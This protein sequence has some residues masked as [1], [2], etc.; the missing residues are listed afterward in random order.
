MTKERPILFSTPMVRALRSGM[1][2]QTRRRTRG[3]EEIN[4][5]PDRWILVNDCGP[6]SKGMFRFSD[7][8]AILPDVT[9]SCPYGVA[10]EKLWTRESAAVHDVT[11][12]EVGIGYRADHPTGDLAAGDGGYNFRSISDIACFEDPKWLAKQLAW[13]NKHRGSGKWVPSIFL[14]R[15]ASRDTL[16]VVST[17]PERL[18]Y[19]TEADAKAE[20]CRADEDPFWKPSCADPDSGGNP[21]AR[22]SFEYLWHEINGAKS[23]MEN[24]FVWRIEF[25]RLERC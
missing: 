6:D 5:G 14:P 8:K 3:L 13:A 20:G 1:K 15:W 25:R 2:V 24:P 18:Q 22:N 12:Y 10:G 4:T 16:E 19:I 7:R 17:Q 23:W 11:G 9:L 21:S